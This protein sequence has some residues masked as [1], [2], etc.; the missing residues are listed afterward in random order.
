MKSPNRV[1]FPAFSHHR[2]MGGIQDDKRGQKKK[3]KRKY[4][5]L[6]LQVAGASPK[7]GFC[8]F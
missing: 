5:A 7:L 4:D 8:I 3:R 6:I 2:K 1:S